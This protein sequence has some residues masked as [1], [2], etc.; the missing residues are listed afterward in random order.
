MWRAT[1]SSQDVA[2][3]RAV[4][5]RA[6]RMTRSSAAAGAPGVGSGPVSERAPRRTPRRGS[7]SRRRCGPAGPAIA[8]GPTPGRRS[9]PTIVAL[10]GAGR[11]DQDLPRDA[12]DRRVEG[13][14]LDVRLDVGRAPG[15][16]APGPVEV[17][18]RRAREDR[19]HVAVGARPEDHQVERRPAIDRRP[20]RPRAA[21]RPWRPRTTPPRAPRRSPRPSATVDLVD[22][23]RDADRPAGGPLLGGRH[24]EHD[25]VERLDVR[26]RVVARDVAVVAPPDVDARPRD[27]VQHRRA[28]A[29]VGR[30]RSGVDPP[31]VAQSARPRA[32]TAS[33]SASD[34]AGDRLGSSRGRVG[35]D[36]DLGV[37][38]RCDRVGRDGGAADRRAP[39]AT[40]SRPAGLDRL[41]E[42]LHL[43]PPRRQ[44]CPVE[45]LDAVLPDPDVDGLGLGG[46]IGPQLRAAPLGEQLDAQRRARRASARRSGRMTTPTSPR[47]SD[48]V[49]ASPRPT[50]GL[51]VR[52]A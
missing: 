14:A 28:R 44:E 20:G 40:G 1:T 50:T 17:E 9:R 2:D 11:D 46:H 16:P 30:A 33:R 4:V 41:G 34:G 8:P 48:S 35:D 37:A 27:L 49:A 42:Q 7:T 24:A 22:R 31:V 10:R 51:G 5:D 19:Q 23:D 36:D 26:E 12:D 13:D 43:G 3:P 45:G 52:P 32:S 21:R 6:R 39:S 18:R 47:P 38:H 15:S 29:A 25:V